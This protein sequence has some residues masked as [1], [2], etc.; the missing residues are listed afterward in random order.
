MEVYEHESETTILLLPAGYA[1]LCRAQFLLAASGQRDRR[2]RS[3]RQK[4]KH[5]RRKALPSFPL[6]NLYRR[7]LMRLQ[8]RYLKT[9]WRDP[10]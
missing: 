1:P 2:H 5:L 7:H 4:L 8:S 10:A 6:K 9:S 3:L